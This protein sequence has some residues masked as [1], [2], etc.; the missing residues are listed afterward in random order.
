MTELTPAVDNPFDVIR[1]TDEAGEYWSAR[2][3]MPLLGYDK[4]ERFGDAIDRARVAA[5][6]SGH[7]ADQAFSRLREGFRT[8]GARGPA[9]ADYRLTRYGA[10]LVAMNGDPRKAEIAA[11]QTYFAVKTRQAE[12][13]VVDE[14]DIVQAMLDQVRATREAARRA[15]ALALEASAAASSAREQSATIANRLDAIEGKH[16]W[17]A[18]LGYAKEMGLP[19]DARSLQALGRAASRIARREGVKANKVQ[20]A[21]YGRVNQYPRYIW[22]EAALELD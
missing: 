3:L 16:D 17:W 12:V 21:L 1:R 4:W 7:D 5:V 18:A 6:N 8:A 10:Y 2:E 22:D 9:G 20:H 11:A 19:T 15:E 13:A 14:L